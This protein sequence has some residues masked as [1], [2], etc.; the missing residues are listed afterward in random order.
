IAEV[1]ATHS[2]YGGMDGSAA[3]LHIGRER[4]AA[5][6]AD[7]AEYLHGD[8]RR[9]CIACV[10]PGDR[11]IA[12]RLVHGDGGLQLTVRGCII[13]DLDRGAPGRAVIVRMSDQDVCVVAFV[14]GFVGV[15]KID[16]AVVDSATD[17]PGM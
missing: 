12:S 7:G 14:R 17:F 10:V 2:G 15:N 16:T 3:D 9:A 1:E 13:I 4:R 8:V 11:D 6:G 5:V